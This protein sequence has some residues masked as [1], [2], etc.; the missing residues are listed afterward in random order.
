M[1]DKIIFFILGALLATLAYSAGGI[2]LSADDDITL[3]EKLLVKDLLITD[4][5]QIGVKDSN[6]RILIRKTEDYAAIILQ[7]QENDERITLNVSKD[8][9]PFIGIRNKHKKTRFMD[10]N[11]VN[12]IHQE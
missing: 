6:L 3:F 7:N 11:S 2:Q 4:S 1:R 8:T 5:L 9:G 10:A 12:R